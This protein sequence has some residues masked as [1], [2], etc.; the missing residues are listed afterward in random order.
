MSEHQNHW[1]DDKIILAVRMGWEAIECRQE[2]A[3]L[4]VQLPGV[5]RS[6]TQW[7]QRIGK[8]ECWKPQCC[9]LSWARARRQL[10]N[11]TSLIFSAKL[12]FVPFCHSHLPIRY[13]ESLCHLPL[14]KTS[15]APLMRERD[16]EGW[17][18]SAWKKVTEQM[19]APETSRS[20]CQEQ[21][22]NRLPLESRR[23]YEGS[24]LI[25]VIVVS[26]L[27]RLYIWNRVLNSQ[28]MELV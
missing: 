22:E 11:H 21:K 2:H 5:V 12:R 18:L 3:G 14:S 19:S 1:R 10:R 17:A 24:S 15:P 6:V 4:V 8:L 20:N 7:L 25:I 26:S 13:P 23:V 16:G 27:G 9:C 28:L